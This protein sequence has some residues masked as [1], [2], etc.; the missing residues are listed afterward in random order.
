MS[1]PGSLEA[2][3]LFEEKLTSASPVKWRLLL[4][5]YDR[6]IKEVSKNKSKLSSLDTFWRFEYPRLVTS[7]SPMHLT[8][9]D[10]SKVMQ[11]KLT[12]GKARPLQKLVDSN[13][14]AVVIDATRRGF[15]HLPRSWKLAFD[16]FNELKGIG[17]ATASAIAA[18][19]FPEV[20]VFMSDECIESVCS[21]RKYDRRTYADVQEA[22]VAKANELNRMVEGGGKE[23]KVFS[24]EDVGKV[25]Y[26]R[27]KIAELFDNNLEM[28]I[29]NGDVGDDSDG[30]VADGDGD[31]RNTGRKRTVEDDNDKP[32]KVS[33]RRK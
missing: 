21:T 27:A 17:E 13:S 28:F 30:N 1:R 33:K 12:R 19:L 29:S 18:P 14:N 7:R 26:I 16:C 6:I 11:W 20:C 31:R 15:Q 10:L 3:Q 24:A 32:G 22:M 25:I 2:R 4:S 9:D 23:K 5:Q 8:L